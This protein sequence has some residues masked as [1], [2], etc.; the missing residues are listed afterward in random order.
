MSRA[1]YAIPP[2]LVVFVDAMAMAILAPVLAPVVEN[3]PPG[4]L[5][6]DLSLHARSLVYGIALGIQP[7]LAVYSAP[8]LGQV[9]DRMGRKTILLFTMVGLV[10]ANIGIGLAITSAWA[11]FLILGRVINGLSAGNQAVAQAAMVDVSPPE[12]KAFFL[13]LTL[14]SSSLGFLV[15]PLVGGL[16]ADATIVSWFRPDVPFY[17]L[18]ALSLV[19]LLL[20]MLCFPG[21]HRDKAAATEVAAIDLGAGFRALADSFVDRT[22]CRISIMF[23]LM[24]MA[25]AAYFLFLPTSLVATEGFTRAEVGTFMAVMGGG[26]CIG[27]AVGLPLLAQFWSARGITQAGLLLTGVGMVVG[28]LAGRGVLQWLLLMPTG[29]VVLI[30]YGAILTLYSDAVHSSQQGRILGISSA[31]VN[32]AWGAVAVV[33]GYLTAAAAWAPIALAAGLMALSFLV[34]LSLRPLAGDA[35]IP[36]LQP[37]NVE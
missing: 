17:A 16:L 36:E 30:A 2:L 31:V 33:A 21:A 35:A 29:F 1:I 7:L 25:C 23:L 10:L 12:K 5:M 15:G 8:L 32:L 19:T 3:P 14:F 6:S 37:R 4:G 34:S 20:I 18:A 27:C 28:T 9:S 26:L 24:Q 22:I 11:S 13:S